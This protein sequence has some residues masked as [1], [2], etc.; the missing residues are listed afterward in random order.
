MEGSLYNLIPKIKYNERAVKTA[1]FL[2]LKQK[3]RLNVEFS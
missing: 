1:L 3:K 2:L